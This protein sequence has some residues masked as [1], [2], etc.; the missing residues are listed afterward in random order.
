[1]KILEVK[2]LKIP[3]IK[4]IKFSRFQDFRGYFTEQFRKS[5]LFNHPELNSMEK[6]NF[7]QA[8]QSYSKKGVIRGMHFQW[9]PYMGKLVRTL[10]GEM[11]DL[12]LDIRKGSPSY[13]KMVAYEMP[14]SNERGYDEWIWIPPGFAHGNFFSKSSIIEY[15]CSGEYSPNCESGIS[16][17]AKDIDWSLCDKTLKKKF[18]KIS[19]STKLITEKDK[20]GFSLEEWLNDEKSDNFIYKKLKEKNLC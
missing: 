2:S 8:N 13:G 16:P 3:E 19:N 9:S 7:V 15:M 17:L 10:S 14:S 18:D 20:N 1:M 12:V 6:I 5:D 11:I 4:I